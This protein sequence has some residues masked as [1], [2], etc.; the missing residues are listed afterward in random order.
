MTRRLFYFDDLTHTLIH[1]D[2]GASIII[3]P[4]DGM[5]YYGIFGILTLGQVDKRSL[6]RYM[7]MHMSIYGVYYCIYFI[8]S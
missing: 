7:Y 1:K 8:R 5:K 6:I 4:I 3:T 2:N